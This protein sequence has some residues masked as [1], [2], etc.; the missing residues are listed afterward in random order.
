[1]GSL[2]VCVLLGG[3]FYL[4]YTLW[5]GAAPPLKGPRPPQL[6]V[7]A[8]GGLAKQPQAC[9]PCVLFPRCWGRGTRSSSPVWLMFHLALQWWGAFPEPCNSQATVAPIAPSL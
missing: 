6:S 8:P 7:Q 2:V 5:P 3:L 1:M 9:T 4:W